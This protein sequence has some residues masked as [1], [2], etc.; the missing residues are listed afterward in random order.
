M[1]KLSITMLGRWEVQADDQAIAISSRKAAALLANLAYAPDRRRSREQLSH[2]LWP[3][4]AEGGARTNLRQA[5]KL[6][7]RAL[8]PA[9]P[10]AILAEGDTLCLEASKVEV[11]VVRFE[12]LSGARDLRSLEDAASLYAGDLLEGFG[13]LTDPFHDWA[14]VEA[15]RLRDKAITCLSRLMERREAEGRTE[16]AIEVG[17]RLLALDPLHEAVHRRLISNYLS[18]GQRGLAH[19]QFAHF[20]EL[21]ACELGIEPEPATAAILESRPPPCAGVDESATHAPKS[22][23][24]ADHA[25][26][27]VLRFASIGGD[28]SD[29]CFRDG[30]CEELTTALSGWRSFPLVASTSTIPFDDRGRRPAD[31]S[32]DLGARYLVNGA[33]QRSGSRLR[34]SVRLI[35]GA[36]GRH[37]WAERINLSLGEIFEAQEEAAR[38][39]AAMVEPELERAECDRI[40]LKGTAELSAWECRLRGSAHLRRCTPDGTVAARRCFE[41]ALRIDG[42]YSDA[43]AGLAKAHSQELLF[44]SSTDRNASLK[45]ALEAGRQAVALDPYSSDAHLAYAAAQVWAGDVRLA[46]PETETAVALNPSNAHA[47]MALGNRLDLL[48]ESDRG[49]AEMEN[50]LALNPRDPR[51]FSYMGFLARACVSTGRAAEALGWAAGAVRLRPDHA[52][53]HY[54]LAVCLANLDR[55]EEAEAALRECERLQPGFRRSQADWRPYSDDARNAVF[56]SGLQRCGLSV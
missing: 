41:D 33:V 52:D 20:R 5:L 10:G 17:R 42:A 9:V 18:A 26:V 14:M 56:F 28:I 54:R 38:K 49:I 40:R 15:V 36:S 7:R 44:R 11:D 4:C 8:E 27:A 47:R 24:D 12:A 31:L 46:I 13:T 39:I 43:H 29:D 3:D 22:I 32:A 50:G 35:D 45:H 25:A 51:R 1:T 30:L 16:L 19:A 37:L 55:F 53:Q 21:L 34:I 2:L 6:L 48:G 23:L